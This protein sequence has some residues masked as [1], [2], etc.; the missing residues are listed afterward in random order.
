[1]DAG[2]AIRGLLGGLMLAAGGIIA[3]SCGLCTGYVGIVSIAAQFTDGNRANL[4]DASPFLLVG[5]V[6][7]AVGVGIAW[8]GVAILR[9]SSGS[10]E[11]GAFDRDG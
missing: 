3:L 11:G 9:A 10:G 1:M 4:A 6:A 2:S 8:G 5:I 7:T